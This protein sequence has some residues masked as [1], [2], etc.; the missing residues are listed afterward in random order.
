LRRNTRNRVHPDPGLD[1]F[2]WAMGMLDLDW[3]GML[4]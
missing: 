2:F 3:S 1:L 4:E